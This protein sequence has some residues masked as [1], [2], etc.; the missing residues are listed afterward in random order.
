MEAIIMMIVLIAALLSVGGA[1]LLWGADS[2]DPMPD[3][4]RR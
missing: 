3:D 2:R 4:H 1:A